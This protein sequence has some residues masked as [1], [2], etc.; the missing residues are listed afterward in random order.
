[1]VL[2]NPN[3]TPKAHICFLMIKISFFY[4]SCRPLWLFYDYDHDDDD[5]NDDDNED[6]D[7]EIQSIGLVPN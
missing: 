7:D 2:V 6:D 1:M 3:S 4:E 5:D